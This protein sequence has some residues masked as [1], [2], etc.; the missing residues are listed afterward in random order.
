MRVVAC[1]DAVGAGEGDVGQCAGQ[2]AAVVAAEAAVLLELDRHHR[3]SWG[4]P[5]RTRVA[6]T[7]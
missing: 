3:A 6:M 7:S 2:P 1:G 4:A 5:D